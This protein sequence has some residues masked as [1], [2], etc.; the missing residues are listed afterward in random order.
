MNDNEI[1]RGELVRMRNHLGD[2]KV[3]WVGKVIECGDMKLHELGTDDWHLWE[4]QDDGTMKL[5]SAAGGESW[6]ERLQL[7]AYKRV[8]L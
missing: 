2:E 3:F 4:R 1:K 7:A 6:E 8:E 5:Y